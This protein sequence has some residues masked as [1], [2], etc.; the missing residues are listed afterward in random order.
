MIQWKAVCTITMTDIG[1]Y[2]MI[3]QRHVCYS[4]QSLWNIRLIS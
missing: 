2:H 1:M 3:Q 4:V